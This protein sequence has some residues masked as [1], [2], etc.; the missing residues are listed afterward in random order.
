[1]LASFGRPIGSRAVVCRPGSQLLWASSNSSWCRRDCDGRASPALSCS[2]TQVRRPCPCVK[3]EGS[4]AVIEAIQFGA[5]GVRRRAVSAW[6]SGPELRC[7]HLPP[8]SGC[9]EQIHHIRVM[10]Y[11]RALPRPSCVANCRDRPRCTP[12]TK[13]AATAGGCTAGWSDR[14]STTSWST[15]PA[16]RLTVAP[17]GP[18]AIGSM[19]TSYWRCCCAGTTA[20]DACGRYCASPPRRSDG[21]ERGLEN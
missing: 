18:R 13:Q 1:M 8:W 4:D 3:P 16:S 9:G 12:A 10:L 19:V 21:H 15:R 6:A 20:S 7:R 14:A 2:R 11:W 17:G 5:G